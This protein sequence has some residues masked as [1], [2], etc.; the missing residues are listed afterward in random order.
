[1]SSSL[2]GNCKSA[3]VNKLLAFFG[4]LAAFVRLLVLISILFPLVIYCSNLIKM[5]PCARVM[6]LSSDTGKTIFV[7]SIKSHVCMIFL[8][9]ISIHCLV[10]NSVSLMQNA[11]SG[12]VIDIMTV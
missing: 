12:S 11:P 2:K 8:F 3:S 7:N 5:T 1:M 9:L 10:N 6:I 4:L